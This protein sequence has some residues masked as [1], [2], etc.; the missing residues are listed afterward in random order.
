MLGRIEIGK[1]Y[2]AEKRENF[3]LIMIGMMAIVLASV[4]FLPMKDTFY[5]GAGISLLL[6]GILQSVIKFIHFSRNDLLHINCL[7]NLEMFSSVFKTEELPRMKTVINQCIISRNVKVILLMTGFFLYCY[8]SGG[9][10][11][12]YLS[13]GG[14]SLAVMSF[15]ALVAD[16]FA[17]KRGNIY[18]KHLES[19][20][21]SK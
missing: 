15:L 2:R 17:L 21:A 7:H 3:L 8:F 1:Y 14:L 10:E 16:I 20:T 4:F 19:F 9:F 12:D 18:L 5:K 11:I 6:T 13:G